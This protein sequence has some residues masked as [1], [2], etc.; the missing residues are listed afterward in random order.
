MLLMS[1]VA[2]L[3]N[4]VHITSVSPSPGDVERKTRAIRCILNGSWWRAKHEG[5]TIWEKYSA[6][7]NKAKHMY[8]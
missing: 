7:P 8:I 6:V 3:I 4:F 2:F 1:S 5:T